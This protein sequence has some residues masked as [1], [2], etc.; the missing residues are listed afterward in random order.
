MPELALDLCAERLAAVPVHRDQQ[1]DRLLRLMVMP[2]VLGSGKRLSEETTDKHA[3]RVTDS[4]TV[5]DGVT[6]LVFEPAS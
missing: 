4:R 1:L 3:R 2:V 5:E 6:V